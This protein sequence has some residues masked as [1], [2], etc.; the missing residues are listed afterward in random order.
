MITHRTKQIITDANEQKVLIAL[1]QK[2]ARDLEII[3]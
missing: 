3:A 1:T 2:R